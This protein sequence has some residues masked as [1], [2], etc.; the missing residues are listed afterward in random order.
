MSDEVH[1]PPPDGITVAIEQAPLA[2]DSLE[3]N[4]RLQITYQYVRSHPDPTRMVQEIMDKIMN[5]FLEAL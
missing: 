4:I 5:T 3:F 2:N 1:V